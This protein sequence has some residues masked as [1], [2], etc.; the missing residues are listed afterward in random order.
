MFVDFEKAFDQE[1]RAALWQKLVSQN[2]SLKIVRML[3]AIYSDV[4]AC[5][6]S[7]EGLSDMVSCPIDVK[8]GCIISSILFT[9]LLND[10]QECMSV[11]SN[12]ID[13]DTMKLFVLLFC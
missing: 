8:Q 12:G 7:S 9:L 10:L 3:K 2:V 5:V 11:G 13:L 4:K 1:D 6:K